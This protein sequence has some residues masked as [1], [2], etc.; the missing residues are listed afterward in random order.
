[1]KKKKKKVKAA[2]G[3]S[4]FASGSSS[5]ISTPG[6][7]E[8]GAYSEYENKRM[9]VRPSLDHYPAHYDTTLQTLRTA[10]PSYL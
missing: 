6:G 5:S 3:R 7:G 9:L 10:C 8:R 1:M 2:A 4:F